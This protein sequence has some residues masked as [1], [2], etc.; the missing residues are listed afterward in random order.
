MAL[1]GA[2][3]LFF[4]ALAVV[5][6]A[7]FIEPENMRDALATIAMLTAPGLIAGLAAIALGRWLYGS[8][9]GRAPLMWIVRLVLPWAGLGAAV[10]FFAML[11][12]VFVLGFGPEDALAAIKHALGAASGLLAFVVGR[13]LRRPTPS[14]RPA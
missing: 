10:V 13:R 7:N 6:A 12:W 5:V 8:W 2:A 11:A 3:A 4:C 9:R 14:D 1:G